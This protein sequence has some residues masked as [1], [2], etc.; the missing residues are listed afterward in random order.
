MNVCRFFIIQ[1]SCITILAVGALPSVAAPTPRRGILIEDFSPIDTAMELDYM[2]SNGETIRRTGGTL[3]NFAWGGRTAATDQLDELGSVLFTRRAG[4][5]NPVRDPNLFALTMMDLGR[6]AGSYAYTRFDNNPADGNN[7]V[8][9]DALIMTDPAA[10]VTV[11]YIASGDTDV[12][13]LLRASGQ[14]WQS[15]SKTF[16]G[17]GPSSDEWQVEGLVSTV[18]FGFAGTNAVTWRQVTNATDMDQVDDQGEVALVVSGSTGSP[19]FSTVDG[20]GVIITGASGSQSSFTAITFTNIR[21]EAPPFPPPPPP[22][23]AAGGWEQ[24]K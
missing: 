4:F 9:S 23:A 2:G 7:N 15:N 11:E 18:D 16:T 3:N 1:A 5:G 21:L 20:V 14:W 10:K 17:L 6:T 8:P 19:E 13:L 24:F 22:P 12:A